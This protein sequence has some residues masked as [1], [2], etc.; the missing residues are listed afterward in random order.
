MDNNDIYT[1]I[2][3]LA[4]QIAYFSMEIGLRVDLPTYSG[5]LGV[6]AGDTIKAAADHELAY[7]AVTLL[8]REGYFQQHLEDNGQ[9][10]E[11]P[12]KWN[13]TDLLIELD[14]ITVTVEIGTKQVALRPWLYVVE[15]CDGGQVPVFF[16]DSDLPENGPEERK[17]TAQLYGGDQRNRLSQEIILGIGG[18]RLLSALEIRNIVNFHLNEGHAAL[19]TLELLKRYRRN[20]EETWDPNQVWNYERVR[21]QCVFTTHT[22]V[23]AG[24]DRFDYHL[25]EELLG[26]YIPI[27]VLKRFAGPNDLNLTT[28]ALNLSRHTNAVSKCHRDVSAL[29]F[30]GYDIKAVTNGVHSASWTNA[31]FQEL[32]DRYLPGWRRDNFLLRNAMMI[33][34]EE[35]F[36]AHQSA[37]QRLFDYINKKTSVK[38]DPKILTIGFARRATPY[39][40]ATLL[41]SDPKR[42]RHITEH[43]GPLQLV[44]A[45][46]AHPHDEP[47]KKL[48]RDI[49]S[50]REKLSDLIKIVYLENYDMEL[51]KLI[52]GGVDLWLN[53]P[54]RPLEASGTSGMKAAH[55]GV[56]NFSILDGWWIEGWIENKTGWAIG[57]LPTGP[58]VDEA[59]NQLDAND[60]YEKLEKDI[61]PTYYHNRPT[62][63]EIMRQAISFN[64]SFFNTYRMLMEY[65]MNIYSFDPTTRVKIKTQKQ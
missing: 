48:I 43:Y 35:I 16:L 38:L 50:T 64:A 42:L 41:F 65:Y 8:Y 26:A 27:D 60:L 6:L 2:K 61:I 21:K 32:F 44:L 10:V 15:G 55:N 1:E 62:W 5:G 30:P 33:P 58:L 19:L 11:Q 45:G 23:P 47:G 37:K 39:K 24:H 52:T 17:L 36:S 59:S 20:I 22:P 7:V 46:K 4:P 3:N 13:P 54:T 34:D 28:L 12:V 25:V 53:T 56:P 40:R 49:F 14:Q 31:E 63:V 29:M 9:Q 57:P 51:G 18:L